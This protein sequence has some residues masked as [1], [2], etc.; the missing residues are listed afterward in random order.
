[1][2]LCHGLYPPWALRGLSWVVDLSWTESAQKS[3]QHHGPSK[4]EI[5]MMC[6]NLIPLCSCISYMSSPPEKAKH[7][8]PGQA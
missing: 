4:A 7:C 3:A 2:L 1:M 5:K 6:Y 8:P